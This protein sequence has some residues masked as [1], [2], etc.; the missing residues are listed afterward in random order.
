MPVIFHALPTFDVRNL[1]AGHPDFYGQP[2][3][4]TTSSG[5]GTPCRH[6]LS[7][8]PAGET[9][10]VLS[11]RPFENNQPYAEVGPIF[12]CGEKCEKFETS[13]DLP[14]ILQTSPEYLVKGYC[15]DD[16]IVYGTGEIVSPDDLTAACEAI[17]ADTK[18]AYI[19][20]R[21]ARNNCYMCKITR[22]L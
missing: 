22:T 3:E 7:N 14:S 11:Y 20:V 12:L 5:S 13:S 18:V 10:L 16:R 19:H 6:C 15:A 17:F 4:R 8:T 9:M 21:S 1:Q 2:A